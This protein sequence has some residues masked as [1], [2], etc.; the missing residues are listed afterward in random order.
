M[1]RTA[2]V[3]VFATLAVGVHVAFFIAAPQE[4]GAISAG[5]AGESL[6]SI[7]AAD[8][9]VAEMVEDWEQVDVPEPQIALPTQPPK[10]E[11]P[12]IALPQM[13]AQP[14]GPPKMAA[15]DSPVAPT[16]PDV[17]PEVKPEIAEAPPETTAPTQS[18]RPKERP[19]RQEKPKPKKQPE[20]AKPAK[21]AAPASNGA[22]AQRAAGTGNKGAKGNNGSA[23]AATM[24]KAQVESLRGKWGAQIRSR[25]ERRKRYPSAAGR[26][27]GRAI[28]QLTVTRGGQLAGVRL[29]R[30]SGNGAID[31]AALRAVQSAGRFPAAPKGLNDARYTFSLPMSFKR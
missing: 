6:A 9:S 16:P 31:Q 23:R 14:P 10:F 29:A 18:P 8:Q 28:V 4:A 2:E 21:K 30:S 13:E 27:A 24:S 15:M 1:A 3:M 20:K 26:A 12:E 25:I 22:Q 19:A 7:E 5:S 17:L 11:M